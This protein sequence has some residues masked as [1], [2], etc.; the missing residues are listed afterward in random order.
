MQ[1]K[2]FDTIIEKYL[3]D[4]L[5]IDEK[6]NV[7]LWIRHIT[8]HTAADHLT[9]QEQEERGERI[10]KALEKRI[11]QPVIKKQLLTQQLRP[12]FK[13]A[14]SIFICCA[15][16]LVF[17]ARLQEIFNIHQYASATSSGNEIN[18]T[19][20]SD[21]SIV[22][23]KGKSTLNYPLKFKGN[24]RKVN[25]E[26]EAL[27]EIAK[28]PAHPFVIHCAGLNTRV[29][30]TSFNIKH[31]SRKIEVNV[32]TGRV[33]LSSANS[34][35]IILHPYQKAVYS[36][37]KKTIVKQAEPVVEVASLIR[38]TEYNMQFNDVPV[39]QVL[40]RIEKKFEV[41]IAI[42]SKK[43]NSNRITADFTDQ[44]LLNTIS[45]MSEAFNMDFQI[46]GQ[47]VKLTDKRNHNQT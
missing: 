25:L 33:F 23:L 16:L 18:K 30:G 5:D 31:R 47:S 43:L 2:E 41:H 3:N 45:M 35:A 8:D 15:L 44:S 36:E 4:K 11:K 34:A 6:S 27:F 10:F 46:D 19:I 20:L 22:W 32:L 26:G 38:G 28:D 17:R 14:A 21:G 39:A 24:L 9:K 29:L 42:N 7:E 12:M 1:N 40:E 37:L 13:I